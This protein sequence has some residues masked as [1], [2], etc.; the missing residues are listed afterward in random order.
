MPKLENRLMNRP[1][2][3]VML[4]QL[5]HSQAKTTLCRGMTAVHSTNNGAHQGFGGGGGGTGR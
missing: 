3:P 2:L 5:R 1:I 4:S